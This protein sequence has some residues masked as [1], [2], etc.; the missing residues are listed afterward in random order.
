M[1]IS[2]TLTTQLENIH[3]PVPLSRTRPRSVPVYAT[4]SPALSTP[5]PTRSHHRRRHK[6]KISIDDKP[7]FI[8]YASSYINPYLS[9]QPVQVYHQSRRHVRSS[10]SSSKRKSKKQKSPDDLLETNEANEIHERIMSTQLARNHRPID[11]RPLDA[12]A[13]DKSFCQKRQM[14]IDNPF[15]REKV[16]S[17]KVSSVNNLITLIKELTLDKNII[18]RI[19]IIYYWISQNIQY[20]ID[21]DF[22]SGHRHQKAED[23]FRSGKSTC[24]GYASLFKTLCDDLNIHC[25]K[26]RGYAKD[27]FFKID[28]PAFSQFNHTWN[29]VQLNNHHWY[30]IDTAWGAGFIDNQHKYKQDLKPHYFLTHPEHMI[31]NHLPEDVRWQLLSKPIT[32]EDYLQLPHIHSYYFIHGLHI[33]SPRFSSIVTFNASQ[34]FAEVLIQTPDDIQLTC[35]I[36]DDTRSTSLTQYDSTRQVWQCLFSPYKSGFHTLIIFAKQLSQIN[37]FKNVIELGVTVHS[38]DFIKGKTLPM[39]FGKFSEYKCQI[40]SPL[41]GALKRGT[42][43]TIRCRIPHALSARISL[44]GVWLDEVTLVNEVFKQQINVPEQEVII[45]AK[46][47]NKKMNKHYHGLIRYTVEK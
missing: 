45:Y 15:Y 2:S 30:L 32:M 1:V 3:A 20:D 16:D 11:I 34:S 33:I 14:I 42:K 4:G 38:R 26:I 37:L 18:D 36:K 31:Y 25:E 41:D 8:N 17:W 10:S 40:I 28:K 7:P 44:D 6:Q 5:S 19:W 35:S 12:S 9:L 13:F 46:F 43:V 22:S 29:A 24:E 23:V 21:A 27:Y 47:M 39:T